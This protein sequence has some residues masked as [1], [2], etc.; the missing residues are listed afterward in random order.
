M[1]YRYLSYSKAMS[2]SAGIDPCDRLREAAKQTEIAKE[3]LTEH[4]AEITVDL[5]AVTQDLQAAAD[6]AEAKIRGN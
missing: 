4:G 5:E 2:E 6:E 1:L 3:K